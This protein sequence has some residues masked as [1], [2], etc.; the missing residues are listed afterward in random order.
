MM[1][2]PSMGMF[3]YI[4]YSDRLACLDENSL[5]QGFRQICSYE[6]MLDAHSPPPSTPGSVPKYSPFLEGIGLKYISGRGCSNSSPPEYGATNPCP[7]LASVLKHSSFHQGII[8][9]SPRQGMV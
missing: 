4:P 3:C 1:M 8:Q 5:Y 2:S 7:G 6:G 9:I